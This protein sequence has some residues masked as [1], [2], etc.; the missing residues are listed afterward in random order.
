MRLVHDA[1]DDLA[2]SLVDVG[3]LRPDASKLLICRS[4]L[5]DNATIPSCIVVDINDARGSGVQADL[6]K[7]VVLSKVVG[8][9]RASKSVIGEI[10]PSDRETED[11]QAI[12]LYEVV[13]LTLTIASTVEGEGRSH[14]GGVTGS[15]GATAKVETSNVD[16]GILDLRVGRAEERGRGHKGG[17][18]AEHLEV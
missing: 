4:T 11:V 6:D 1:K 15:I 3:Q 2:L 17:E 14:T 5:T 7:S 9:E 8:V 18:L 12:V 16:T 10:L 13:H